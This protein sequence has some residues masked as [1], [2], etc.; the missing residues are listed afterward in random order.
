MIWKAC[1]QQRAFGGLAG[2]EFDIEP[3][4]T[5]LNQKT[6]RFDLS[7]LSDLVSDFTFVGTCK[8]LAGNALRQVGMRSVILNSRSPVKH[9]G[10]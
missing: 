2:C 10:T 4:M 1:L 6:A 8:S 7:Q 3:V 9:V 5:F